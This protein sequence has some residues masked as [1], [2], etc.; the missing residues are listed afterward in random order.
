MLKS[1]LLLLLLALPCSAQTV[2][3]SQTE[4]TA[5]TTSASALG[6]DQ[7]R[8]YLLIQNKGSVTIYVKFGSASTG[9]EGI[10]IVSGGNYEPYAAPIGEIFIKSA[11]STSAVVLVSGR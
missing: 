6:A 4:A 7:Y 1:I 9:T 10:A 3:Q 8:S 2:V 5:T 11:S